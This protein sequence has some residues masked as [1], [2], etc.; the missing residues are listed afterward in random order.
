MLSD[1]RAS[2]F[3]SA[4]DSTVKE[5]TGQVAVTV[6]SVLLT[7]PCYLKVMLFAMNAFQM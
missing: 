4:G 1:S 3:S 2:A 6:K 7:C 5:A